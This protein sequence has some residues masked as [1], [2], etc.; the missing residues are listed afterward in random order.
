MLLCN[1]TC[2]TIQSKHF[3]LLNFIKKKGF[4]LSLNLVFANLLAII[5]ITFSSYLMFKNIYCGVYN[6]YG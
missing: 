2:T 4:T 1:V 3:F 6:I 5:S